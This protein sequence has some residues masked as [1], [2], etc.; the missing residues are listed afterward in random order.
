MPMEDQKTTQ[1][2]VVPGGIPDPN[3]AMERVSLYD[4]TG[5]IDIGGGGS[6]L[7]DC[8]YI[9]CL[10]NIIFG[11]A[12]IAAFKAIDNSAETITNCYI[13]SK[14]TVTWPSIQIM[15]IEY[16]RVWDYGIADLS[17]LRN[18]ASYIRG[19]T[20]T[21]NGQVLLRDKVSGGWI[22]VDDCSLSSVGDWYVSVGSPCYLNKIHGIR[23][24]IDD[25]SY[26]TPGGRASVIGPIDGE[27]GRLTITNLGSADTA[28]IYAGGTIGAGDELF[29][30]TVDGMLTLSNCDFDSG[31]LDH[32]VLLD[33]GGSFRGYSI[34]CKSSGQFWL[35][36]IAG[37]LE[38]MYLTLDMG[39]I[40][41]TTAP[42]GAMIANVHICT[43]GYMILTGDS[44]VQ[45]TCVS[46]GGFVETRGWNMTNVNIA[47]FIVAQLS[48]D[49]RDTYYL[50]PTLD[51]LIR[52][53]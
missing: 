24:E 39:G 4:M 25:E 12:N 7:P 27:M 28:Y 50:G 40:I 37:H 46:V 51:T 42:I 32:L 15:R 34:I 30:A 26:F 41:D 8:V 22:G 2:L 10:G 18:P 23:L 19:L 48:G 53:Y 33:A 14:A 3:Q 6:G 13:G 1:F 43:G 20:I 31:G 11:E 9:D 5:P 17:F 47:G 29:L 49:N 45:N 38:V 52:L 36:N 35:E 44:Q 16:L 21:G